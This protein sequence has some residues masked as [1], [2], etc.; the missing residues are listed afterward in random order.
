MTISQDLIQRTIDK[1]VKSQEKK[2]EITG[3]LEANKPHLL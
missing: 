3:Y 2:K 1:M